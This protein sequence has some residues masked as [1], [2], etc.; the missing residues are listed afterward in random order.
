LKI[1]SFILHH[2][3]SFSYDMNF[4]IVKCDYTAEDEVDETPSG[5][6][7]EHGVLSATPEL[8]EYLAL[9][10]VR[11]NNPNGIALDVLEWWRVH[12]C[13]Y[14]DVA[15]MA[16]DFF[17]LPASSAG[18]ERLFSAAGKKHGDAQKST[19][20]GSLEVSLVVF[21]NVA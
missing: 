10:Q 19:S 3:S 18:V 8:D 14:P 21:Q 7:E 13:R 16:R 1:I 15:M 6:G 9:P 11:Q 4:E 12:S 17:A 20:E 2:L 5:L